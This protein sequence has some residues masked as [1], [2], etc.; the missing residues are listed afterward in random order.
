MKKTIAWISAAIILIAVGFF[1]YQFYLDHEMRKGLDELDKDLDKLQE[2][3][4]NSGMLWKGR[5]LYSAN[6]ID[7]FGRRATLSLVCS[8]SKE[9]KMILS[10]G[11]SLSSSNNEYSVRSDLFEFDEDWMINIS[12]NAVILA[13]PQSIEFAKKLKEMD[14]LRTN[15][16]VGFY[17]LS[18]NFVI[19]AENNPIEEKLNECN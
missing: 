15:I 6:P 11:K 10:F 18:P 1:G 4:E 2:E 8:D 14:V 9:F 17:Q 19:D 12:N 3:M 13:E 7:N 5:H 16:E